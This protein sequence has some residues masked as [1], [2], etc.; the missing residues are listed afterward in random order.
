[1]SIEHVSKA[2]KTKYK[3]NAKLVLI[4]I[5]DCADEDGFCYPSYSHIQKHA[6][7]S[8]RNTVSDNLKILEKDGIIK[9]VSRFNDSNF[10]EIF[11][12]E[13]RNCTSTATSTLTTKRVKGKTI[14]FTP[15]S[16]KEIESYCKEKKYHISYSEGFIDFYDSKNWMVG[17]NKMSKWKSALSGW[18]RRKGGKEDGQ[19]ELIFA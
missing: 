18:I 14:R 4:V 7:I 15:P 16:E 19:E 12:R 3:A 9:K 8:S 11:P 17:K 1:M 5:A 13:Y 6:S 10:Y 2:L